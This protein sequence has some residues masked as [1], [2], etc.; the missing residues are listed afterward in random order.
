MLYVGWVFTGGAEKSGT[1]MN[2]L[3]R[4]NKASLFEYRKSTVLGHGL[5]STRGELDP[6]E[7][8]QFRNPDALVAKVR[9]K[10]AV[11]LLHVIETD[12]AGLLGLTAVVN[13]A[14]AELADTCNLANFSHGLIELK[15]SDFGVGSRSHY[16]RM[17]G[18]QGIHRKFLDFINQA[19]RPAV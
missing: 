7:F 11:H 2:F 5:Q 1:R 4:L 18:G 10:G 6:D 17:K 12:T 13:A 19:A 3:G 16:Y 15:D 14:A 9:G 8:L